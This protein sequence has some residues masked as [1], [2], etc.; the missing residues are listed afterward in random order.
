M[1]KERNIARI[2]LVIYLILLTWVVL[3]KMQTS[4]WNLGEFRSLNLVPYGKSAVVNGRVDLSELVCNVAAFIPVG[5]YVSLLWPEWTFPCKILPAAG[6]SL[7]YEIFQYIF[8]IGATDI[9]DWINNT[10]GG[11][12]GILIYF[13]TV[14]I[15]QKQADRIIVIFAG[16][17]TAFLLLLTA[18]LLIMN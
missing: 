12:L 7:C 16:I 18:M 17:C 4:L 9:T 15:F 2:L 14:R 1:K 3:F 10:L 5:I 8:G 6:L 11:L 13:V